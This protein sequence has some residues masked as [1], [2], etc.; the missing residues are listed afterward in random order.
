MGIEQ[1]FKPI[2]YFYFLSKQQ[3]QCLNFLKEIHPT[4]TSAM[5]YVKE[6][7]R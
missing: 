3:Y 6:F 5:S 1:G 2:S 4:S 7:I